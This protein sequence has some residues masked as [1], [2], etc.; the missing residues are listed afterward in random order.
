MLTQ[1][2]ETEQVVQV[3]ALGEIEKLR[4]TV[5]SQILVEQLYVYFVNNWADLLIEVDH[6]TTYISV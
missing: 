4:G 2:E 6:S 3:P 1:R 5:A